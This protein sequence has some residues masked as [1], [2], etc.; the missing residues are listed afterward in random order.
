MTQTVQSSKAALIRQVTGQRV[1]KLQRDY[2][3]PLSRS[4]SD[5][6]AGLA[7]LRRCEADKPGADPTVWAITLADLP[8]ELRC[9]DAASPAE[10]SIFAALVLYAVHQQS[11]MGEVH[12]QGISL[13]RAVQHL[14]AAR[15]TEGEPDQAVIRRLHQVVLANDESG[16]LYHLRGLVT[17]MRSEKTPIALDYAKLAE[18]LWRL[19]DP[20]QDSTR[21]VARW[22]RDLYN[23]PRS[24]NTGEVE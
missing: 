13:G 20:S 24:T 17:L 8:E 22:G 15:A 21:V 16:R 4:N 3:D 2:L 18:D 19:C 5:A 11:Q 14:A 1:S 9:D 10:R 6:V 12:R 7:R 23:R